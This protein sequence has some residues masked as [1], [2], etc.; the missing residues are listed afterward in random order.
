MSV[1]RNRAEK[2]VKLIQPTNQT[3]VILDEKRKDTEG[4]PLELRS[5]RRHNLLVE[6]IPEVADEDTMSIATTRPVHI[7]YKV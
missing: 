1:E 2:P 3:R 7:C 6:G 5:P 4:K